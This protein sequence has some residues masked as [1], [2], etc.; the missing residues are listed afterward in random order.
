[1]DNVF[2]FRF[3]FNCE[4]FSGFCSFFPFFPYMN[5][6]KREMKTEI[7][8][9]IL[10]FSFRFYERK[11]KMVNE[12]RITKNIFHLRFSFQEKRK[13]ENGKHFPFLFSSS[14]PGKRKRKRKIGKQKR[15]RLNFCIE[16]SCATWQ[17]VY[18][19]IIGSLWYCYAF[20]VAVL[21]SVRSVWYF[22]IPAVNVE[23]I[24]CSWHIGCY[25]SPTKK[26]TAL[27]PKYAWCCHQRTGKVDVFNACERSTVSQTVWHYRP[28]ST[29]QGIV[30]VK[31][32]V[33]YS[34]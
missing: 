3:Q 20:S 7:G 24:L 11:I 32:Q 25:S 5:K 6:R 18:K 4:T 33:L 16:S 8:R 10:F 13:N 9:G 2:C 34:S 30:E 17:G 21:Q 26:V 12:N 23:W 29:C 22:I 14:T 15:F 1:M 31:T 19:L 27:V 28:L